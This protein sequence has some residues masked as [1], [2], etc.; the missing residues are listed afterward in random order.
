MCDRDTL[1]EVFRADELQLF[2]CGSEQLDFGEWRK[3][4]RYVDGF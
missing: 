2:V 1:Q 3:A 4:A